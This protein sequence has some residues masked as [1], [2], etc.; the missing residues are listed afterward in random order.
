MDMIGNAGP[1]GRFDDG[2]FQLSRG[3]SARSGLLAGAAQ[4]AFDALKK[5]ALVPEKLSPKPRGRFDLKSFLF[6]TDGIIFSDAGYPVVV[7]NEHMNKKH[8]LFRPGYHD[9]KDICSWICAPYAVGV[10]RVALATLL[11]LAQ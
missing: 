8:H 11:L 5:R 9:R 10:A 4:E 1:N 7:F 3:E 6:Q 2:V